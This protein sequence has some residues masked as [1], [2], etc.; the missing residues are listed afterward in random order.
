MNI[1]TCVV[2]VV[3]IGDVLYLLCSIVY[4][5][6]QGYTLYLNNGKGGYRPI[7]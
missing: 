7:P 5:L 6:K 1:T 3:A 2:V 4:P